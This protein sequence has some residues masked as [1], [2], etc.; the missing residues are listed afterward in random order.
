LGGL[1]GDTQCLKNGTY[2]MPNRPARTASLEAKW[3][4]GKKKNDKLQA[5]ELL[6]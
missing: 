3:G 4:Y 2:S 5:S 1:V 6:E